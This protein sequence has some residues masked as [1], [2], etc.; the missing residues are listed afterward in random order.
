MHLSTSVLLSPESYVRPKKPFYHSSARLLAC[1]VVVA[2]AAS[3]L[4][5]A[6]G[7]L[8]LSREPVRPGTGSAPVALVLRN[9][10]VVWADRVWDRG[11]LLVISW[12][13]G[14]VTFAKSEIDRIVYDA[15]P[16]P[17]YT[18]LGWHQVQ[19]GNTIRAFN[20]GMGRIGSACAGMA[21]NCGEALRPYAEFLQY[22]IPLVG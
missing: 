5:F 19:A 21:R 13:G 3:L 2:I 7:L 22:V 15:P 9:G 11:E 16:E 14:N 18:L 1:A 6:R 20:R 8:G 4:F 12:R 17:D 10:G